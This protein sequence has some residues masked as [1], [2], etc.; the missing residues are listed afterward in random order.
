MKKIM[1]K[2]MV[3]GFL[4]VILSLII[5]TPANSVPLQSQSKQ[6]A[7]IFGWGKP[8]Y[9]KNKIQR[10][11]TPKRKNRRAKKIQKKYGLAMLEWKEVS[12]G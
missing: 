3:I 10:Q 12:N 11:N 2:I 8:K 1:I 7:G 6:I 5:N 9:N 4:A